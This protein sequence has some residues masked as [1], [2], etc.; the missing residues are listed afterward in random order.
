MPMLASQ[1]VAASSH[2]GSEAVLTLPEEE[3]LV[4]E[5]FTVTV[6]AGC[7]CSLKVYQIQV[8]GLRLRFELAKPQVTKANGDAVNISEVDDGH[9]LQVVVTY[10]NDALP[11]E[12]WNDLILYLGPFPQATLAAPR[13]DL[14]EDPLSQVYVLLTTISGAGKDLPLEL[15]LGGAL[16]GQAAESISFAAPFVNCISTVGYGQCTV[17]E[18]ENNEV[19]VGTLGETML[20][21]KGQGFGSN[22]LLASSSLM[23]ISVT[24]L[25]NTTELCEESG[26]V[27][28]TE[29]W[30]R[31][32]PKGASP[33][34]ML[35]LGPMDE[36]QL[37]VVP[38]KIRYKAPVIQNFSKPILQIVDGGQLFIIGQNFPDFQDDNGVVGYESGRR[39]ESE[40]SVTARE[41]QGISTSEV[42]TSLIHVNQTHLLCE[43]KP[44]IDLTPAKCRDVDIVVAWGDLTTEMQTVPLKLPEP[45]IQAV[46][47]MTPGRPLPI[48]VGD[49]TYR[50]DGINFGTPENGRMQVLVGDR[51]CEVTI[52]ADQQLFCVM[53]GPL[54]DDL[55]ELYPDPPENASTGAIDVAVPISVWVTLGSSSTESSEDCKPIAANWSTHE[56]HLKSC[57]AG[58]MRQSFRS[59]SCVPCMPGWYTPVP[60]PFLRCQSCPEGSYAF[61][62]AS[63]VCL[64]CPDGRM[65]PRNA[66]ASPL[67]CACRPGRFLPL[68]ERRSEVRLVQQVE[69]GEANALENYQLGACSSC[70][71]GAT[72]RGGLEPPVAQPGW[73]LM[74]NEVPVRCTMRGCLGNNTCGRGYDQ[75]TRCETCTEQFYVD[76]PESSCREC[77]SWAVMFGAI[78]GSLSFL[79]LFGCVFPFFSWKARVALDPAR[80]VAPPKLCFGLFHCCLKR[81]AARKQLVTA[82]YV[83][84]SLYYDKWWSCTRRVLQRF[85]CFYHTPARRLVQ[86]AELQPV[87]NITINHLQIFFLIANIGYAHWPERIKDILNFGLL[88][89]NSVESL[90]PSCVAPIGSEGRW[91]IFFFLPYA[92]YASGIF[93]V[94]CRQPNRRQRRR[95]ILMISGG[96][97]LYL[98]PLHLLSASMIFDCVD[99]AGQLVLDADR[100]IACWVDPAWYRMFGVAVGG[101]VFL[102]I[103]LSFVALSVY[104]TYMWYRTAEVGMIPPK[105]VFFTWWWLSGLR[106]V[107]LKHRAA[108]QGYKVHLDLPK[109]VTEVADVS[110]LCDDLLIQNVGNLKSGIE[111][112]NEYLQGF[113]VDDAKDTITRPWRLRGQE[114]FCEHCQGCGKSMHEKHMHG[115]TLCGLCSPPHSHHSDRA[116]RASGAL[117]I[118]S[119][120]REAAY[121]RLTIRLEHL[122]M[123]LRTMSSFS[124]TQISLKDLL[125]FTWELI[126]LV[127]KTALGLTRLLNTHDSQLGLQ[128]SLLLCIGFLVLS[129][130]VWPYRHNGLNILDSFYAALSVLCVYALIQLEH[131]NSDQTFFNVFVLLVAASSL[132]ALVMVPLCWCFFALWSSAFSET[133]Y[134]LATK[135]VQGSLWRGPSSPRGPPAE[136]SESTALAIPSGKKAFTS[137]LTRVV[138][139]PEELLP[140]E[141][142][143]AQ[144]CFR[145]PLEKDSTSQRVDLTLQQG[146][147]ITVRDPAML[148]QI[149]NAEG[150]DVD[151]QGKWGLPMLPPM[152]L[153]RGGDLPGLLRISVPCSDQK[154]LRSTLKQLNA[155]GEEKPKHQHEHN[156]RFSIDTEISPRSGRS[157]VL[158]T[159][160][161]DGDG[162]PE[163]EMAPRLSTVTTNTQATQATQASVVTQKPSPSNGYKIK[164]LTRPA[165]IGG[166]LVPAGAQIEKIRY[167]PPGACCRWE[168]WGENT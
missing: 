112:L 95:I 15:R 5:T 58:S 147:A 71:T 44:R 103:V 140:D 121:N 100:G 154:L 43:M 90:R 69:R 93:F 144:W 45:E 168:F 73:W 89:V 65:T 99:S 127:H 131:Y 107:S 25:Y 134:V 30:C 6:T 132:L 10:N 61:Q 16:V 162:T 145:I 96:F 36:T 117:L 80:G 135:E 38:W 27:S 17:E 97:L 163:S 60:G 3:V 87:V 49:L 79:F 47:D 9:R 29:M 124:D 48:E 167:V 138:S 18:L 159:Q 40:R 115:R 125:S 41:L 110:S 148:L 11:A 74:P 68:A 113:R 158:S 22:E 108:I 152:R 24:Q 1:A 82:E 32:A 155:L 42:C 34:V 13:A 81:Y 109:D 26:W 57:L 161:F 85:E 156:D 116:D 142:I 150:A 137:I 126:V 19:F 123:Q 21:V 77:E 151:F 55:L 56:V 130:V 46:E 164:A 114:V 160:L 78:Y 53:N 91:Y 35:L 63:T 39:L 4:T 119:R 88:M 14:Q 66:T 129:L 31:L 153:R 84:M 37:L 86:G 122:L 83:D 105:S 75:R 165:K 111:R 54:R 157:S 92:L 2:N 118:R 101:F 146:I 52:R 70:P 64:D 67:D 128:L 149:L 76:L 133:Y 143:A 23:R 72:C 139:S 50:L 12:L 94:I 8:F 28:Y 102:F 104:R 106:G 20:Y 141:P 136:E 59:E 98:S 120:L 166:R 62:S 33:L 7:G 51:S